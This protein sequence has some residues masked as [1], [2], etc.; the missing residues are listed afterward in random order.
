MFS[1]YR[2]RIVGI[3][4]F[5]PF[6]AIKRLHHHLN[7]E[8]NFA[9]ISFD[10]ARIVEGDR[11]PACC[12]GARGGCVGACLLPMIRSTASK[13]ATSLLMAPAQA[14]GQAVTPRAD[15]LTAGIVL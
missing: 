7:Y 15:A 5:V 3:G 2:I 13:G 8:K 10:E 12:S 4:E 1:G 6:F 11:S 14:C 9:S